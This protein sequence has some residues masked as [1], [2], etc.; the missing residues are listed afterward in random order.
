MRAA[1]ARQ[2]EL[3]ALRGIASVAVLFY[4]TLLT[5]RLNDSVFWRV[6]DASPLHPMFAGRLAVIFFFVL[7]GA[8]LTQSLMSE[9]GPRL[10]V[11]FPLFAARRVVR[12]CLPAAA[13]LC[14]SVGLYWMFY[15]GP[16]PGS[17]FFHG[18]RPTNPADFVK[19]AL[20]IG[21]DGDFYLDGALWSLVHEFRLSL[22]L[23]LIVTVPMFRGGHGSVVVLLL[24]LIA[25]SLSVAGN[26]GI[27]DTILLGPSIEETFRATAYFALPFL[28]GAA[29][30]LGDWHR[31]QPTAEQ[32]TIAL[33]AAI[34][35]LCSNSDLAIIVASV[36]LILL[37]RHDGAYRRV[38]RRPALLWL[39][40]VSFSLYL[41]H[42][43]VQLAVQHALHLALPPSGLAVITVVASL[44]VASLMHRLVE[45]PAQILSRSI[46]S[47]R[48]SI[49]N[50]TI[51][52]TR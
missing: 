10:A 52:P 43:P 27:Q 12:L 35:L 22:L 46:T 30:S 3:D 14:L 1:R 50:G 47:S 25:F 24:G 48:P 5:L 33:T 38:L 32:R 42:M 45:R 4:H 36:L 40:K 21:A 15:D 6:L 39:G 19:Q 28:V 51:I 9:D 34:L 29:L 41:V 49:A 37:S 8:V 31:W 23:P 20:L 7:S 17:E 16:W 18:W 2:P 11:S 44:A 13:S 26:T